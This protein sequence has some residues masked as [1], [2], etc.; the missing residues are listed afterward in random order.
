MLLKNSEN[1]AQV[2]VENGAQVKNRFG[3]QGFDSV[4]HEFLKYIF[5]N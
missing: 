4:K 3:G 1:T 5:T 2:A